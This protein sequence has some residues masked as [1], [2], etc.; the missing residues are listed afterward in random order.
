M[1]MR[2]LVVAIAVILTLGTVML[3]GVGLLHIEAARAESDVPF[4]YSEPR[5]NLHVGRDGASYANCRFG[6]ALVSQSIDA[7]AADPLNLGWYLDWSAN[8]NPS[9]PNGMEYVQMVRVGSAGYT[10][11]GSNLLDIIAANPGSL[12][13][14]GN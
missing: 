7:Y 11:S 8:L 10:P 6:L 9:Q 1:M 5:Q 2:R 3:G 12:W 13:L 14:I 4:G